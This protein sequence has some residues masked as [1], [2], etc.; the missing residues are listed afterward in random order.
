VAAAV[1]ASTAAS[2]ASSTLGRR[3]TFFGGALAD[4]MA[5]AGHDDAAFDDS[6]YWDKVASAAACQH[7]VTYPADVSA[8]G[9]AKVESFPPGWNIA[10]FDAGN[11]LLRAAMPFLGFEDDTIP[12]YTTPMLYLGAAGT[13]FLLHA[14][15][16]NLYSAN[17]LHGG[18]PKVWYG[19]PPAYYCDVVAL[20]RELFAG[21]SLVKSCPQAVMVSQCAGNGARVVVVVMVVVARP[22]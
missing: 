6:A 1:A 20:V 8:S 14:E 18:A 15:D 21:D 10:T 22:A 13:S 2:T 9:L 5:A 11:D 12:G 4:A 16:Q 3:E 7:V 19:V 17:Y